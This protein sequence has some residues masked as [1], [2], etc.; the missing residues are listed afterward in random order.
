MPKKT[1][2]EE[3]IHL[4]ITNI[5]VQAEKKKTGLKNEDG[6]I[7]CCPSLESGLIYRF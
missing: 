5:T 3:G 2:M 7:E 1:L 4:V 6:S